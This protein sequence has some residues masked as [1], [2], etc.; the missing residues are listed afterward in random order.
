VR[1]PAKWSEHGLGLV[2]HS[3]KANKRAKSREK[4]QPEELHSREFEVGF[5]D[6]NAKS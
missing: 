3:G 4:P 2:F 6:R 1:A 5:G